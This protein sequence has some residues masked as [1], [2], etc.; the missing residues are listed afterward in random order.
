MTTM[1]EGREDDAADAGPRKENAAR[2]AAHAQP[3]GQGLDRG[4]SRSRSQNRGLGRA[5]GQGQGQGHG[6]GRGR[7]HRVCVSVIG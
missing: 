4:Q 5:Q 6:R 7:G 1:E 2:G 3:P